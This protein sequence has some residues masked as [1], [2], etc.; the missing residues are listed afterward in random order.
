MTIL[1]IIKYPDENLKIK[2][3]SLT[4]I[5]KNIM[6]IIKNM[7]ETMFFFNG[8]GLS[9]PQI[10]Y[11]KRIIVIDSGKFISPLI[12]INPK[13]IYKKEY[14]TTKEGCLSFP[15]IFINVTRFKIIKIS[16]I[17][18]QMKKR[19]LISDGLLSICIQHEIDH[20]N[21][22]TLYDKMS[23]LKRKLL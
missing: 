16:Y 9:A 14:I 17:D 8:V 21:G 2:S 18:C 7:V 11:H 3:T 22:I 15:N 19:S 23:T 13:I 20:L 6:D 10:N 5:N 12:I 1:N 4:H